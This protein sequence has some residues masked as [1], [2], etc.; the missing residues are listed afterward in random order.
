GIA[1]EARTGGFAALPSASCAFIE[2][3]IFE[4]VE[5]L[6]TTG[7]RPAAVIGPTSH[8]R[9]SSGRQFWDPFESDRDSLSQRLDRLLL[10]EGQ[11][12]GFNGIGLRRGHAVRTAL[13]PPVLQG[14][15]SS[16]PSTGPPT[17]FDTR[18]ISS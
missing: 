11:Q 3:P 4:T 6:S 5:D 15:F 16:L 8:Q 18:A 12:V 13:P 17:F 7:G 9:L 10:D 1:E 2:W 14:G